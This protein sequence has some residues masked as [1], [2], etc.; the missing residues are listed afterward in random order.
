MKHVIRPFGW[1][2]QVIRLLPKL[3]G[4]DTLELPTLAIR[5]ALLSLLPT[6]NPQAKFKITTAKFTGQCQRCAGDLF[7]GFCHTT[8]GEG[9]PIRCDG[10]L[11]TQDCPCLWG[12][13]PNEQT[14][15][16]VAKLG[17]KM[18]TDG[19]TTCNCGGIE[20]VHSLRHPAYS[21]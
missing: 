8:D 14:R 15:A 7:G 10:V 11:H 3:N 5:A 6:W 2:E 12:M 13:T 21:V 19:P 20:L 17:I 1:V 4:R 9:A 16:A 18:E